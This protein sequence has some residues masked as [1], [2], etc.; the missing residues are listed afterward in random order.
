MSTS[1][2]VVAA[3]LPTAP[4]AVAREPPFNYLSRR[5]FEHRNIR[6]YEIVPILASRPAA[7]LRTHDEQ[8]AVRLFRARSFGAETP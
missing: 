2:T 7:G 1:A 6:R 5:S 8:F 3:P 4:R